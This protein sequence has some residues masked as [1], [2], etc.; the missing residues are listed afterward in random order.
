MHLILILLDIRLIYC[1]SWIRYLYLPKFK[2]KII[3]KL[4]EISSWIQICK[5]FSVAEP[6]LLLCRPGSRIQKMYKWIRIQI[7][8]LGG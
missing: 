1:K 7:R 4:V 8:I 2:I 6:H 5:N 3:F